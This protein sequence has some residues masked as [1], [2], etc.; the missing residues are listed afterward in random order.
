MFLLSA[1][2]EKKE[3]QR[4]KKK[5]NYEAIAVIFQMQNE[6]QKIYEALI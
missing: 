2:I 1:W 6:G 5:R 4:T 3:K